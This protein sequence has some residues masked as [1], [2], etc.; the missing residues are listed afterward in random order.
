MTLSKNQYTAF[1]DIVGPEYISNNPAILYSYSWRS[2]LYAPPQDFS[3]LFEAIILPN[4]NE[5][6]Q[7]IVKLC[8]KFKIQFKA[9]STGWGPYNDAT[10]P[11]CI[12]LDL[13]RMN[14][15]IEINVKNMYAVVEPGLLVLNSRP[16]A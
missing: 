5:E 14:R 16:N 7:A 6:I 9:S 12:K 1:E 10:A 2:G 4:T 11:G 15:I 13:R 3:P 8:N